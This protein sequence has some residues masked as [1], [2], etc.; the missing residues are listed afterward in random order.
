MVITSFFFFFLGPVFVVEE[1]ILQLQDFKIFLHLWI[2]GTKKVGISV[3]FYKCRYFLV[4][5]VID[6]CNCFFFFFALMLLTFL[7][8]N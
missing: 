3:R 1:Q 7:I 4:Y 6:I 5:D 2:M 8:F